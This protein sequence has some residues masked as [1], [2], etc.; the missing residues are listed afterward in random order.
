MV[1]IRSAK[2][3]DF[4]R[5]SEICVDAW[6]MAKEALKDGEEATILLRLYVDLAAMFSTHLKVVEVDGRVAGLLFARLQDHGPIQQQWKLVRVFWD[7]IWGRYGRLKRPWAFLYK[8]LKDQAKVEKWIKTKDNEVTLFAVDSKF[9][10]KGLGRKLMD[11]ILAD[12]P[13]RQ[14]IRLTTDE[15]CTYQFYERYGFVRKTSY[16]EELYPMMTMKA[17]EGYIYE[18]SA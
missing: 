16:Q 17:V 2:K 18:Y 3:S 12:L 15:L 6:P 5:C 7:Y 11:H 13:E 10:G 4:P 8:F 1:R 9:R 14:R